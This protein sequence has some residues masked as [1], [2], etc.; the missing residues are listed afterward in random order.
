[1]NII[2]V[3]AECYPAAK[4]GGLADV[5]GS[6]PKYMN[7]LEAEASVIMPH[8]MT[9]WIKSARTK[10]LFEGRA[11]L[12]NSDFAF[13]IHRVEEPDLGF[14]FYLVDIPGRFDRPGVYIDPWSGFPYWDEKER[15]FSFQ[16]AVLEWLKET[17]QEPDVV[18]CHDHH[19][20]LIPFMMS[21]S[22]RYEV[23][24]DTPS[25]LTIHNG[26][27]QGRYHSNDYMLLPA[28]NLAKL[29]L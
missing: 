9:E 23:F 20:S 12:G 18:H 8:Y 17:G 16:I 6:L 14:K 25:V 2:H 29:G 15:F 5:V 19:S 7:E 11:P 1:M 24:A 28:F 22:Y 21:H 3:S 13:R 27:Y 10:L 4:A 26:E